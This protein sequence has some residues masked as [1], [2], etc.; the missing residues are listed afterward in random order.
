MIRLSQV[1]WTNVPQPGE[2]FSST[3]LSP[4]PGEE[5]RDSRS[6]DP[7]PVQQARQ[8][9]LAIGADIVLDGRSFR[10]T[11]LDLWVIVKRSGPP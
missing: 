8:A 4:Q 9:N 2:R 3:S 11:G 6:F 5:V 10:Q 7:G 1:E